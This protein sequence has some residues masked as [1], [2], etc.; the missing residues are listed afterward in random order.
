MFDEV[1]KLIKVEHTVNSYGDREEV[2]TEKEVFCH[3]KSITR[4]E[5][6]QA[7]AEGMKP[8]IVF[9]LADYMDYEEEELLEYK[10]KLYKLI[11][12]YRKEG[13]YEIELTCK[14]GIE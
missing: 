3:V 4:A 7:N 9:V 12:T 5:F 10:G 8:S 13:S 1:V 11:R 6:Y 14:K 2:R